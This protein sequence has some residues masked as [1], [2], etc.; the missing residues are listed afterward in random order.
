MNAQTLPIT[1][2]GVKLALYKGIRFG[3]DDDPDYSA[4]EPERVETTD[5][6]EAQAV[7]SEI[8]ESANPLEV[9]M[10]YV[11][12]DLDVPAQL[13]PSSTP[14]HSHLY[15]EKPVHWYQLDEIL[16]ALANAGVIE[17]GYAEV[18]IKRRATFLRLPWVKKQ[19]RPA[20]DPDHLD[21]APF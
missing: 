15:I 4:D 9:G 3:Q 17:P 13:V 8:R 1:T 10:H 16:T 2:P 21:L 11:L 20:T 12:L 5:L 7:S 19:P 14:G 18:S 6:A